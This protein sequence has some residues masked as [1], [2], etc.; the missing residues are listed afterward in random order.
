MDVY[1]YCGSSAYLLTPE[2]RSSHTVF[3]RVCAN[4]TLTNPQ[5]GHEIESLWSVA[6]TGPDAGRESIRQSLASCA[7][8]R[9][10]QLEMN[11]SAFHDRIEDGDLLRILLSQGAGL[12]PPIVGPFSALDARFPSHFGEPWTLVE[13]TDLLRL[14]TFPLSERDQEGTV[15]LWLV[16]SLG[17]IA[18]PGTPPPIAWVAFRYFNAQYHYRATVDLVARQVRIE[19]VNGGGVVVLATQPFDPAPDAQVYDLNVVIVA[20]DTLQATFTCISDPNW[21]RSFVDLP[22]PASAFEGTSAG[23]GAVGPEVEFAGR[24]YTL[25]R[26]VEVQFHDLS[27][28]FFLSL[29]QAAPT[30]TVVAEFK[31]AIYAMG[32]VA[33][34]EKILWYNSAQRFSVGTPGAVMPRIQE[35]TNDGN[36]T[37][38]QNLVYENADPDG[39]NRTPEQLGYYAAPTI[40]PHGYPT[41]GGY[42]LDLVS[43]TN[44]G[45]QFTATMRHRIILGQVIFPGAAPP[46]IPDGTTIY[47]VLTQHVLFQQPGQGPPVE[48]GWRNVATWA[49]VANPVVYCES[50]PGGGVAVAGFVFPPGPAVFKTILRTGSGEIDLG[51]V[52]VTAAVSAPNRLALTLAGPGALGA[53]NTLR[54]YT[55]GTLVYERVLGA[56]SGGGAFNQYP[57]PDVRVVAA[58]DRFVYLDGL[59]FANAAAVRDFSTAALPDSAVLA[60][61]TANNGSGSGRSQWMVSWDGQIRYPCLGVITDPSLPPPNSAY[62][63]LVN[64]SPTWPPQF[65]VIKDSSLP[66]APPLENPTF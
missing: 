23:I 18:P 6:R 13:N 12:D 7:S 60:V 41:A 66:H 19:Q 65:D 8:D 56:F 45:S 37:D 10:V 21:S 40:A 34:G 61:L 55:G 42:R 28:E 31:E 20:G 62:T 47:S 46:R 52:G 24:I 14:A 25:W 64:E 51:G 44:N 22:L 39:V 36:L 17:Q 50:L 43:V 11:Q 38:Y 27:S 2:R 59:T 58:S 15:E 33:A 1:A 63:R 30:P 57:I 16:E 32:A 26:L 49:G 3:S 4:N 9:V 48:D 54:L 29:Y 53:P 35:L 5:D